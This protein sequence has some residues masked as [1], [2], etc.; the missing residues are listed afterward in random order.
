MG[1]KI[2]PI[3]KDDSPQARKRLKQEVSK[4]LSQC[5][6]KCLNDVITT[7]FEE[8]TLRVERYENLENSGEIVSIGDNL[9]EG[10]NKITEG[11]LTSSNLVVLGN[12]QMA[13]GHA[14]EL[15]SELS[16]G[17]KVVAMFSMQ[18]R[19]AYLGQLLLG[20]KSNISLFRIETGAIADNM[21]PS[22]T[23]S[24]GY[25][26]DSKVFLNDKKEIIC[27]EIKNEVINLKKVYGHLDLVIID[28]LEDL[29]SNSKG[30]GTF[31]DILEDFRILADEQKLLVLVLT[32]Q[33]LDDCVS[34]IGESIEP[35][36]ELQK[37]IKLYANF[38]YILRDLVPCKGSIEL[39][40]YNVKKGTA[41]KV[42]FFSKDL[43]NYASYHGLIEK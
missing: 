32:Q 1:R 30:E 36:S 39:K 19:A 11:M 41:G 38:A 33:D 21:W 26:S 35:Y 4:K 18:E 23:R 6:S 42:S 17:D 3:F 12:R 25:L 13:V 24:A 43:V 40:Y 22:L 8:L 29:S 34:S 16:S 37:G 9:I 20:L 5:T 2:I 28:N 27:E 14:L 31:I 15:M 10:I 7:S